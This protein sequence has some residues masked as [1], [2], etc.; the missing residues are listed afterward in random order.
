MA[1]EVLDTENPR[2][3]LVR[4]PYGRSDTPKVLFDA[5]AEEMAS[6]SG[7]EKRELTDVE[8]YSRRE[9]YES[10]YVVLANEITGIVVVREDDCHYLRHFYIRPE[11]RRCG[12]GMTAARAVIG[13][14]EGLWRV[15]TMDYNI[16]AQKF[17]R[18]VFNSFH[19]ERIV[20]RRRQDNRGP[21]Y[22]FELP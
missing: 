10:W 6:M 5:F 14:S 16:P 4:V 22:E 21:Q 12:V 1:C 20:V 13:R 15:S 18:R 7:D 8:E 3:K 9:C 2:I 19:V 11:F 17:W